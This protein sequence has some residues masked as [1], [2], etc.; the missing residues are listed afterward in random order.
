[1]HGDKKVACIHR[2][3]RCVV[4]HAAF[5]PYSLYLEPTG[6]NEIDTRVNNLQNFYS[7]CSS[8]LLTLDRTYAKEILNY[9]GQKQAVTDKDRAAVSL[10]Y[11]CLS[12]MDIYWVKGYRENTDFKQL[13]LYRHSLSD[14]FVDVSLRG[15]A[16]TVQ[17]AE[18]LREQDVAG[19]VGTPGVAPKAWIRKNHTFSLL[20]DGSERDVEAELLASRILDC[21][22]V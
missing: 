19:D 4:Y 17:N 18:L 1:M 15:K 22:R 10:T 16:V 21:F 6:E 2:D 3:G 5:M 8:R 9:L 20:K 13:N 11:H 14:A 7:W 12:L